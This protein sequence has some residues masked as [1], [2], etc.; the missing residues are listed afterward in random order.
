MRLWR[1]FWFVEC[2]LWFVVV[3]AFSGCV[4][5][6]V[7]VRACSLLLLRV[8]EFC[9]HRGAFMLISVCRSSVAKHPPISPLC[10]CTMFLE[11][12]H[13]GSI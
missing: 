13:L 6:L 8:R 3:V 5:M 4:C 9:A 1:E 12:V 11:F 7:H 10:W 2:G